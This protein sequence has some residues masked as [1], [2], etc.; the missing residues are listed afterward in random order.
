MKIKHG[1]A[2]ITIWIL[3]FHLMEKPNGINNL[4]ASLDRYPDV[5][6]LIDS[7]N[8]QAG[9]LD[10]CLTVWRLTTTLLGKYSGKDVFCIDLALVVSKYIGETEKN[11]SNLLDKAENKNWILFFDE[12]VRYLASELISAMPMI[13][14]LIRKLPIYYSVSRAT[15]GWW[16]CLRTSATTSTTLLPS[17]YRSLLTSPCPAGRALSN[18]CAAFPPQI[19]HDLL[20]LD[21]W[22]CMLWAA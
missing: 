14:M 2:N 10:S 22:L 9:A 12:A 7:P 13:N 11:L 6:S 19:S 1:M 16:Y 15:A 21:S 5:W 3:V 18:M 20:G 8:C 17:V 4:Y